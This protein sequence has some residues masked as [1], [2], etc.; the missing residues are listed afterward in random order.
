MPGEEVLHTGNPDVAKITSAKVFGWV[1]LSVFC[2]GV[3]LPFIPLVWW[4]GRMAANRH[5]YF[6]TVGIRSVVDRDMT[7]EAQGGA[8]MQGMVDPTEVQSLI[9]REVGRVNSTLGS[10]VSSDAGPK[11]TDA[12]GGEVVSLLRE[13]REALVDRA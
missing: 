13:I 11:A 6:V 1:M 2:W 4:L 10:T 9:L 3:T 8:V 5:Q 12:P 7:G